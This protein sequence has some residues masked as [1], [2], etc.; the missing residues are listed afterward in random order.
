MAGKAF[1]LGGFVSRRAMH[2]ERDMRRTPVMASFVY[3]MVVAEVTAVVC[4]EDNN[5]LFGEILFVEGGEDVF[6]L[7]VNE[8]Q[9]AEMTCADA[10]YDLVM[11]FRVL[12]YVIGYGPGVVIP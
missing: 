1:G 3:V 2:H 12:I 11:S 4:R 10:G 5:R 7:A 6:D 8:C 9:S